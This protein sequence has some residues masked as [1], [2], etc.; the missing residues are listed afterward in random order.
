MLAQLSKFWDGSKLFTYSI[1]LCSIMCEWVV[2]L[3]P[4]V[5][6]P[7]RGPQEPCMRMWAPV[8]PRNGGGRVGHYWNATIEAWFEAN[9]Q[10]FLSFPYV[11]MNFHGDP[12]MGLI[13]GYAWS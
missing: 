9:P 1:I 2:L 13:V 8:M 7:T 11:G 12:N 6:V 4:M 5:V 3:I 10:M